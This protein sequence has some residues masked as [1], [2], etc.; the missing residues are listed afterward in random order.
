MHTR[1]ADIT[2][3]L[4]QAQ[5]NQQIVWEKEGVAQGQREATSQSHGYYLGSKPTKQH[6]VAIV[7]KS[8]HA[9]MKIEYWPGWTVGISLGVKKDDG[10]AGPQ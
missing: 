1:L 10:A 7:T 3:V 4:A 2:Q 6:A 9:G 8:G 5:S